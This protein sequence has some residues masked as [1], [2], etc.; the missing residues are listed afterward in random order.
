MKFITMM[1]TGIIC[2]N[3]YAAD[4]TNALEPFQS[5]T[6]TFE[7]KSTQNVSCTLLARIQGTCPAGEKKVFSTDDGFF[8]TLPGNPK[9]YTKF[10]LN[11]LNNPTKEKTAALEQ[12]EERPLTFLPQQSLSITLGELSYFLGFQNLQGLE[13]PNNH[14]SWEQTEQGLRVILGA[15]KAIRDGQATIDHTTVKTSFDERGLPIFISPQHELN[16]TL[17][18]LKPQEFSIIN[19]TGRE[20]DLEIVLKR[21][22]YPWDKSGF[23]NAQNGYLWYPFN[24]VAHDGRVICKATHT[25]SLNISQTPENYT[26]QKRHILLSKNATYHEAHIPLTTLRSLLYDGS[27]T[28]SFSNNHYVIIL[29]SEP[30]HSQLALTLSQDFLDSGKKHFNHRNFYEFYDWNALTINEHWFGCHRKFLQTFYEKAGLTLDQVFNKRRQITENSKQILQQSIQNP[31]AEGAYRIPLKMHKLWLTLE[32]NPREVPDDRLQHY[33]QEALKFPDFEYTIWCLDRSKIPLTLTKLSETNIKVRELKEIWTEFRGKDLF[34]RMLNNKRIVAC[35]DIA[36]VNLIYLLGGIYSDFGVE[37]HISPKILCQNFDLISFR[38]SYLLS[39]TS[40]GCSKNNPITDKILEFLDNIDSVP[41]E[42]RHI[43]HNNPLVPWYAYGIITSM[44]DIYSTNETRYFAIPFS[45]SFATVNHFY[46]WTINVNNFGQDTSRL[47]DQE[48][49]GDDLVSFENGYCYQP[50]KWD[51]NITHEMS[52]ILYGKSREEIAVKRRQ[53]M[54]TSRATYYQLFPQKLNVIPHISHRCWLTNP[55]NPFE[56]P[57]DKLDNYINSCRTLNVTPGWTHYFWCLDPTKIP[58]TIA[59]LQQANVGIIIKTLGD[60]YPHMQAKHV[61]DA[62]MID[63]RYTQASDIAR[64]N[65]VNIFGGLYSDIGI[66]FTKNLSHLIDI[67]EYFFRV[68]E[69][70]PKIPNSGGNL[71]FSFFAAPKFSAI[72]TS[73]FNILK[74]IHLLSLDAKNIVPHPHQQLAWAGCNNFMSFIDSVLSFKCPIFFCGE[75]CGIKMNRLGSWYHQ[76]KFGNKPIGET[77]LNL[78]NVQPYA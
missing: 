7:N 28:I 64:M 24:N 38:E 29:S 22:L 52:R 62:L 33:I 77:Q 2:L 59:Y 55:E 34:N 63:N 42:L 12:P 20:I 8:Y 27:F 48:Y 32:E 16:W 44:F 66:E 36:R 57:K 47:K 14:V 43:G 1:L 50:G 17:D 78:F 21:E 40:I 67:Y 3:V 10:I 60:I 13:A 30:H 26:F 35:T 19:N 51:E 6:A 37:Y 58:E 53:L 69:H 65:I 70:N 18:R 45:K 31:I 74:N 25:Q 11:N 9:Q 75:N 46:S 71:D 41:H 68:E 4:Y 73:Y 72:L 15:E 49:F 76:G 56:A 61:F 39:G 5:R 23:I 54:E